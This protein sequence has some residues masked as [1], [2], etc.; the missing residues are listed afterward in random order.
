MTPRLFRS[1]LATRRELGSTTPTLARLEAAYSRFRAFQGRRRI[2]AVLCRQYLSQLRQSGL[3]P[4]EVRS[5]WTG[6]RVYLRWA[7]EEGQLDESVLLPRLSLPTTYR[8]ALTEEDVERIV[9]AARD[10]RAALLLW[11]FWTTGWRSEKLRALRWEDVDFERQLLWTADATGDRLAVPL[12]A[13]LLDPLLAWKETTTSRWVFGSGDKPI[14]ASEVRQLV[15]EAGERAGFPFLTPG[16][17]QY[18]WLRWYFRRGGLRSSSE[19]QALLAQPFRVLGFHIPNLVT[20]AEMRA[21]HSRV[22][23]VNVLFGDKKSSPSKPRRKR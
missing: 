8:D 17:F 18:A 21:V 6:L 20:V 14:S 12:S 13:S 22:S 9:S 7:V 11:S 15:R 4:E 19:L 5:L 1:F 3:P 23:P 10:R 2:T 16:Q